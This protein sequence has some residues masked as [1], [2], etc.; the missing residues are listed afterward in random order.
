MLRYLFYKTVLCILPYYALI[1]HVKQTISSR[2]DF[3]QIPGE[4]QS[5]SR[6]VLYRQEGQLVARLHADEGEVRGGA[7]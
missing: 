6:T 7:F 5:V 1:Y 4:D 2:H 3:K